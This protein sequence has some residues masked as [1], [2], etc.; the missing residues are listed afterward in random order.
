ML[1]WHRREPARYAA[2]MRDGAHL[3]AAGHAVFGTLCTRA[4]GLNDAELP[5]DIA[6][7]VR[8]AL[9]RMTGA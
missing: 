4:F 1:A 9:A 3:S 8:E 5:E 6:G 7:R 2:L